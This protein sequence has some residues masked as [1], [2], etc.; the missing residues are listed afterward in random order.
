M[1]LPLRGLFKW[2]MDRRTAGKIFLRSWLD[3]LRRVPWLALLA[4]VA[5]CSFTR[6]QAPAWERP[7]PRALP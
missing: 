7:A 6:S 4:G 5:S 2:S 1:L 3:L